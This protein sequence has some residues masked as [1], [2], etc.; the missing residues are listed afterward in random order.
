MVGELH[1]TLYEFRPGSGDRKGEMLLFWPAKL[2]SARDQ[3]EY[4][5]RP[6]QMYDFPLAWG[7]SVPP[8]RRKYVLE[9]VYISP[10]GRRLFDEYVLELQPERLRQALGR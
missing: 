9:V 10:W 5:D 7:G 1:F 3:Q 2:L 6:S 4:W 8:V